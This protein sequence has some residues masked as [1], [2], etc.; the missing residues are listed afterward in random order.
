MSTT[1]TRGRWPALLRNPGWQLRALKHLQAMGGA[2]RRNPKPDPHFGTAAT[3]DELERV[4]SL[5]ED[6]YTVMLQPL[7]DQVVIATV[8]LDKLMALIGDPRAS[9][10]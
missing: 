6:G 2:R 7:A 3:E 5:L 8:D 9:L 10:Y 1:A 4:Q